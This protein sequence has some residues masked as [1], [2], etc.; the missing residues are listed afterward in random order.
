MSAFTASTR[1]EAVVRAPQSEIW[2]A[3]IDPDLIARFTPFVRR[4]T[5][6]GEH[7]V[8]ELTGLEVAGIGV[9]RVFTEQLTLI[10]PERIE[11]HHDPPPG[12][13]EKA[14]VEGWYALSPVGSDTRLLTSLEIT[15]DL[16]VPKAAG[17]AV[18]AAMER[19][20]RTM[21]DRFSAN[22]LEHLGTT[23]A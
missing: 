21:G 15:V 22:L 18:R 16:P 8:W 12:T 4:I 1:A 6:D 5:V 10:E 11:F 7:W 17:G 14:G 9:S 19:V 3:L 2:D 23:T 20:M 13:K